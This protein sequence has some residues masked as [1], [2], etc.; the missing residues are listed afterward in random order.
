MKQ[1]GVLVVD[2]SSF[3]RRCI[4]LIIEK[5][6]QFFIIGIARNGIDAIEKV[7]RLKPDIVTMDLEMPEMDGIDALKE[8]MK[9]SPVPVVML[10]NYTEEG[11]QIALEALE[12]GAVD[13]FLK[14]SLVGDEV[15]EEV[16]NEFVNRLKVI[17]TSSKVQ[18]NETDTKVENLEA[19]NIEESSI[20]YKRDL[21][22]IGCSTGGPSAL[23]SLLPRFSKNLTVPILVIQH[24]PPGFTKALAERFDTICNLHVKE[25]ENNDVLEAGNIYIA[26]AGFQT[27]LERNRENKIFFKVKDYSPIETL[28][29]PS[30][31]VTLNSAAPIFKEKLLTV[32]LTG[33]GN[34]GLI[35]CKNVKENNGDVIVEA[36]E[37]CIVYGMPRVVFEAGFADTQ[38]SLPHIFEHIM[39]N[40]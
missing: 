5:D 18:N 2:D 32:I 15:K 31:N 37:S 20:D 14:S 3:M 36:E 16:V 11:T 34:D 28:Y 27:F 21:L 30:I 33:M 7:Q 29:K 26:P 40:L 25:I 38:V 1:Y 13:F 4:S 8:I 23:Q 39:L 22:I 24:M 9:N 19:K 10:S 6:P 35:G 12:E 17:A